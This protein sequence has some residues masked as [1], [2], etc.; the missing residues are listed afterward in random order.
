VNEEPVVFK[1]KYKL[2]TLETES[3]AT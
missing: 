3:V 2:A 1:W